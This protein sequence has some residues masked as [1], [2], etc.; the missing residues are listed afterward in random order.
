VSVPP[1]RSV[2]ALGL[3]GATYSI[4]DPLMADGTMP[5]LG[6]L[7]Q[8]GARAVLR[9][10]AHPLSPQAWASVM[11]GRSPGNHGIFDFVRVE[12]RGGRPTY[13]LATS[14]DLRCET[15]WSIASRHGRRVA[16]LNFPCT[17]PA[18]DVNGFVVPGYVPHSYLSRAV[19]PRSLY[20]RMVAELK[21]DIRRLSIDWGL[22]R[23]AVQG[24][25]DDELERWIELHIEREREWFKIT[26]FLMREEPC[27]LTAVVFDGV[28]RLQHLCYHLLDPRG[29]ARYDS[30]RD[31]QL[32][33]RCLEYFRELDGYLEELVSLA[34]PESLIL[35]IS[36]H[37]AQPAGDRIFYANVWLEQRGLLAWEEGVPLDDDG[38]VAL[39]DNRES[40]LLFDWSKTRACALT[41]SSNAILVRQASTAEGRGGE[42]AGGEDAPALRRRLARELMSATDPE[43]G[44]PIVERVL[45]RDEAFA[46]IAVDD[47]PDLTLV[48]EEPGFL[49]VL[50][51]DLPMKPRRTPFG[52]HHRD[53]VFIAYG[54]G[55]EAGAELAPLSILSVAPTVLYGLGLTVPRDMEADPALRAF[56]GPVASHEQASAAPGRADG[57]AGD[58]EAVTLDS[59]GEAQIVERLKL[60]G[61]LE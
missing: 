27:Q 37:G 8:Q 45:V 24:L 41:S 12:Q 7:V 14:A 11:T 1:S 6:R 9:S 39:D 2:V 38:R 32:R 42:A 10:T 61:Y 19:H 23:K 53:G 29:R 57:A 16:A 28:D 13:T 40:G 18:P 60:L 20:D 49:S 33:E 50:R 5:F 36:D 26:R 54:P 21:L 51:A 58:G 15:I 34:G 4:L 46:G 30:A 48:L 17:F 47:A 25:P 3:D 43:T 56:T 35:V 52:T 22:E 31:R 44:R 55:I 59:E